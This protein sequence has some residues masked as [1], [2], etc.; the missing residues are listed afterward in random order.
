LAKL[1]AVPIARALFNLSSSV[2]FRDVP[3]PTRTID[4]WDMPSDQKWQESFYA[5]QRQQAQLLIESI[6]PFHSI[7]R[8]PT[9]LTTTVTTLAQSIYTDRS[10]DQL[11][12][13]AD[14]L[15]EQGCTDAELLRHLRSPEPHVRGCW[16]LDAVLGK[17]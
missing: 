6:N 9:W 3:S 8:N 2:A 7:I 10:F 17:E 12:I 1:P 15:E 4:D 13:L 11:P 14:A 16:A 5:S